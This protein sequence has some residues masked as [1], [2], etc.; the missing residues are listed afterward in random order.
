VVF[1]GVDGAQWLR[2]RAA[3]ERRPRSRFYTPYSEPEAAEIWHI[4]RVREYSEALKT[5]RARLLVLMHILGGQ[6][7]R[8]IKLIIVQ[9]KNGLYNDIRELF[10]NNDII[11][12]IIVY[13]KIMNIMAQIK[14][15]YWYLL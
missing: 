8:G 9:Y 4:R 12:F 5:F 3:Q 6:L 14:I 1:H 13:N 15:I 7:A 11:M 2:R 10:I